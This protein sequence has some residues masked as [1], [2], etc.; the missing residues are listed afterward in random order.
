MSPA[1][2]TPLR[3]EVV[4]GNPTDEELAAVIAVV[5]EA[6]TQ[7]A[8]RALADEPEKASAWQVTARSLREPFRRDISWGR[9]G[10]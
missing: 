6:Y 10:G 4:R 5:T 8:A 3:V 9:F 2:E 1:D 7:E